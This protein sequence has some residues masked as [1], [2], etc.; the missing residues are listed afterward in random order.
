MCFAL[1]ATLQERGQF[2]L[3][4][5]PVSNPAISVLLGIL[6]LQQR[7]SH[8]GWHVV[9]AGAALLAALGGAVLITLAKSETTMPGLAPGTDHAR[10]EAAL[11]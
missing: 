9:V 11:A 3:A 4:Q 10:T 5:V 8:P 2:A 1:A 6:L 7:L